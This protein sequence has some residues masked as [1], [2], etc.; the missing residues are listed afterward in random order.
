MTHINNIGECDFFSKV[1]SVAL[2]MIPLNA[3]L[4]FLFL[5]QGKKSLL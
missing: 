1:L 3:K 2:I 5:T 4:K